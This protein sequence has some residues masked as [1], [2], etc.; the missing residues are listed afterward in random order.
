MGVIKLPPAFKLAFFKH[1]QT[2]SKQ[3]S[4]NPLYTLHNSLQPFKLPIGEQHQSRQRQPI[5]Y[6]YLS[7]Y[8]WSRLYGLFP[9]SKQTINTSYSLLQSIL[10]NTHTHTHIK[11]RTED[12][13][14][15]HIMGGKCYNGPKI[16]ESSSFSIRMIEISVGN[17]FVNH[18]L[19]R[20][21]V[22]DLSTH[23][24]VIYVQDKRH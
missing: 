7:Y 24:Q 12:K 15:A 22:F 11:T 16:D 9:K 3:Y 21:I 8:V 4:Q 19:D 13:T 1:S 10:T 6:M 17:S 2:L 23:R 5:K 18:S 14:S 20:N